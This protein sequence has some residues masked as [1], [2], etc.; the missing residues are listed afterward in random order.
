VAELLRDPGFSATASHAQDIYTAR[1]RALVDALADQGVPAHGRSGLN[2]WVPVREEAATVR[3][4]LD[5]NWLVLAG[6]RFRIETP[7]GVR[8]TVATLA[9]ADAREIAS[10]IAGVEQAGRPRRAY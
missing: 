2:V 5:A 7:P 4:L 1:R 10:I 6:E 8:I 9:E 3:A